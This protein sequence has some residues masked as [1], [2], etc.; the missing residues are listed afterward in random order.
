MAERFHCPDT[1]LALGA[2]IE[3]GE[4]ESHHLLR[5]MRARTGQPLRVFSAGREFAAVLDHVNGR[6]AVARLES[7]ITPPPPPAFHMTFALPW[8][9]G[10]RT[11]I[12]IQKLT[13]LGA[14]SFVIFAARREVARPEASKL[15]RLGR[16]AVEACKQC[17]RADPPAVT[18][19]AGLREALEAFPCGPERRLVLAERRHPEGRLLSQA[20]AALADPA[21]PVSAADAPGARG[22]LLV[23]SGPEGGFHPEEMALAESLATPVSLGPRIL[24][25]ETAPLAAAAAILAAGGDL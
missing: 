17:E 8:L 24:R 18:L 10:G 9:K 25:A 21:A 14:A 4:D 23:A 22:R 11:E 1:P 19:A 6:R 3:L 20:L 16:T 7:E 13:E 2:L 15:D 5:V 12:L